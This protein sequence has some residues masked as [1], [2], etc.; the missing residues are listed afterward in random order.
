MSD[1]TM[2]PNPNF[3]WYWEPPAPEPGTGG[4]PALDW[5]V[6]RQYEFNGL[7]IREVPDLQ[8]QKP[9][10][11]SLQGNSFQT[12]IED[13]QQADT[14]ETIEYLTRGIQNVE[15]LTTI[16]GRVVHSYI[17]ATRARLEKPSILAQGVIERI[18]S[19]SKEKLGS[20]AKGIFNLV[21]DG[22]LKI[23]KTDQRLI[24]KAYRV[25]KA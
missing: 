21:R 22:K 16:Q 4:A 5:H 12:L 7:E 25:A 11:I 13:I 8:D 23:S 17:R 18:R 10:W 1:L 2:W 24:W 20:L 3:T 14:F 19:C 6:A 15:N 9:D